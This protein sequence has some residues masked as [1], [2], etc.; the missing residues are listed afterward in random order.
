VKYILSADWIPELKSIMKANA[1][2]SKQSD[3]LKNLS[4][5]GNKSYS[6]HFEHISE[7]ALGNS[8]DTPISYHDYT[9]W[10]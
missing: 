6:A 8:H 1:S 4:S 7:K 2:M 9:D 3:G 10:V 5:S